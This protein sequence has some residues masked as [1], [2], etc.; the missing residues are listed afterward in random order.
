MFKYVDSSAFRT[1]SSFIAFDHGD[2]FGSVYALGY[3]VGFDAFDA[4]GSEVF[5][6]FGR[7][8]GVCA[9][10]EFEGVA[11]FLCLCD[12]VFQVQF[13]GIGENCGITVEMNGIHVVVIF[14]SG[15]R[16]ICRNFDGC[17]ISSDFIISDDGNGGRFF[18]LC[19]IVQVFFFSF[20]N[21]TGVVFAAET[22]G[23]AGNEAF[24]GNVIFR[25]ALCIQ[26]MIACIEVHI[27]VQ[28][29]VHPCFPHGGLLG[30]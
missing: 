11:C 18:C 25:I 21:F 3:G 4:A 23:N 9:A 15:Y 26:V 16:G 30:T 20:E 17:C 8:G 22:V 14:R 12:E 29:Q 2:E 24:V 1:G 13:L 7:A 27:L 19:F 28:G 10:H 6:V 5:I